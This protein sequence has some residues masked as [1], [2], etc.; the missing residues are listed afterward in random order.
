M[1]FFLTKSLYFELNFF[2]IFRL[3]FILKFEWAAE[4]SNKMG[5]VAPELIFYYHVNGKY[6]S[7]VSSLHFLD[8]IDHVVHSG[9]VFPSF[10]P[11]FDEFNDQIGRL[12]SGGFF[13]F[14]QP[15]KIKK[16]KAEDIGPQVL[17]MDHM[18]VA[19]IASMLPFTFAIIAFIAEISVHWTK[20]V[21]SRIRAFFVIK[22][23]YVHFRRQ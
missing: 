6:R 19:L 7:G 16:G 14:W 17:T 23:F 8:E 5:A 13:N 4:T 12:V 22:A 21:V 10:S 3:N 20:I 2:R 18:E 11:F 9:L 1:Q 15:F